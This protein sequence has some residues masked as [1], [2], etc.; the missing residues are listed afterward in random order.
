MMVMV[1]VEYSGVNN[2][3]D[4]KSDPVNFLA[5]RDPPGSPRFGA[6]RARYTSDSAARRL[7]VTIVPG[8]LLASASILALCSATV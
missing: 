4:S 7:Q 3:L 2:G 8:L 5:A 6:L 1:R